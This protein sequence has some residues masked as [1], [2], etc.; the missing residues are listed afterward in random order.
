[1]T[2]T[3]ELA[4]GPLRLTLRPDLG[5]SVAGLWRDGVPV[6]RSTDPDAL[7]G[8][9]QG[10]C[11]ALAPYSN[12]LGWRRFSWEGRE[13][14][15]EPNF[16]GSPHSLHGVAWLRPWEVVTAGADRAELRY[17]HVADAH[18]PF[19]FEV[20]QR[21]ALAPGALDLALAFTN[22]AQATQP[23]GL[24]WHPYFPRRTRSRLH[25]E[26]THR[27]DAGSDELPS[28][29]VEQ[30]GLDANVA[31]LRLDNCFE[32]WRGPARIRDEALSLRLTSSAP[33]VI[34]YTPAERDWFCVEPVSHVNDA[35]HSDEPTAR[36]LVALPPGRTLDHWMRLEIDHA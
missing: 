9:R 27:W 1:M 5:G 10:A 28:H 21:F 16:D 20:R 24:G 7:Q 29:R 19:D 17:E 31:P 4:A 18:W 8:P 25:L 33:Y 22:R 32:G 30:H 3:L 12:R 34:V 13:Y 15:T 14:T 2:S 23:V 6:L 35:I 11:F 36:G 26:V